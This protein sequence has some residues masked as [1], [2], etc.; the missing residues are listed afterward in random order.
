MQLKNVMVDGIECQ[1]TDTAASLV[2]RTIQR[3]TDQVENFKKKKKEEEEEKD[4]LDETIRKRDE[5]LKAKDAQIAVL[6]QQVKDAQD[7]AKLDAAIN[8]RLGVF[9]RARAIMGDTFKVDGKSIT[10]VRREVVNAKANLGEATK[11]W[12]D[13]EYKAAFEMLSAGA[14]KSSSGGITDARNAF[15]RPHFAVADDREKA[16]ADREK[17]DAEAW[18]TGGVQKSA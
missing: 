17:E 10:D 12:G 4:S 5:D 9:T 7:P 13:A 11:A 2:Q 6:T 14:G 1:M 15:S 3:L 8:D 18:R 16:Y